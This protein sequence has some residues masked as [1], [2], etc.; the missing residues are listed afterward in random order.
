[1]ARRTGPLADTSVAQGGIM[2]PS[3]RLELDH[4][5]HSYGR[6]SVLDDIT[7]AI[8]PG[9]VVALVGPS[10]CGKSTLLNILAG[11]LLPTKG[12]VLMQGEPRADC[13]NPL[14][15]VFQDFALLPRRT[16]TGNVSLV[17]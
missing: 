7:F 10:G 13:V 1:M 3:T 5:S 12:R 14:T 2:A 4:V 6:N 8:G 15:Y 17:L 16:V 11:L 9:E